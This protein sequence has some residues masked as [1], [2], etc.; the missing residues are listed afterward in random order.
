[1]GNNRDLRLR[2]KKKTLPYNGA[3]SQARQRF[4]FL[5]FDSAP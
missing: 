1:L 5:R 3:M 4:D 2:K